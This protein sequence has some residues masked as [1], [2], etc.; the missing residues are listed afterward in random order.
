MQISEVMGGSP[1]STS[2]TTRSSA[3]DAGFAV[4]RSTFARLPAKRASRFKQFPQAFGAGKRRARSQSERAATARKFA[5]LRAARLHGDLP[6]PQPPA[7]QAD[8]ARWQQNR[9]QSRFMGQPSSHDFQVEQFTPLLSIH[10]M[11]YC[12][13]QVR[14]MSLCPKIAAVSYI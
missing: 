7:N 3:D 10:A 4:I 12:L 11:V 8:A 2:F 13:V 1:T 14:K 5:A 6:R 9:K